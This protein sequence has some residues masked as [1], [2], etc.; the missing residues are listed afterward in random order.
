M[1]KRGHEINIFTTSVDSKD[2]IEK[3]ENLTIYRYGTNFR[4]LTSN[5]SYGMLKKPEKH[6]LDIVHEH[7]DIPH[8]SFAGLKYA[9]KEKI[10]LVVT[11]HGDWESRHGGFIRR[12][13]VA[14]HN[15]FLVDKLLDHAEVIISP[16]RFYIDESKFLRKYKDKIV[17]IPNGIDL[18]NFRTSLSKIES[19]KKLGLDINKKII[20]FCG[21]LSPHKGPDIAIKAFSEIFSKI[22]NTELIFLGDGIMKNELLRMAK[23]LDL[24]KNI[25]F[26]GFIGDIK[27]KVDYFNSADIFILPSLSECFPI[28]N[29]EAMACGIPIVASKIGGVPDAV[30]EGENGLL[31]LPMN[32]NTLSDA[33]I[34]LLEKEEIREKF[35]KNGLE[36]IKDYSWERIAEKTEKVYE[37]LI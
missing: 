11:Y 35:G 30:K 14:F 28:V 4:V 22:K 23:K 1:A 12:V 13:G 37:S 16:S 34:Y 33:I 31:V 2:T 18:N 32:K 7:F 29:L 25:R 26:I 27:T 8:G 15:K 36:K 10:P 20:L 24:V 21:F 3:Y 9:K 6:A 17:V 5:I 19:R